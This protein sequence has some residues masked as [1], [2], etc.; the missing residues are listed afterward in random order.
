[1][2]AG[3]A[4]IAA[5]LL[6]PNDAR[7]DCSGVNAV[8]CSGDLHDGV[9]Y[10]ST[11][12]SATDQPTS[13]NV[14]DV[15][16]AITPSVVGVS[17]L[18]YESANSESSNLSVT[19]DS[20]ANVTVNSILGYGV[21]LTGV[22]AGFSDPTRG[23]IA[24][25]PSVSITS[26]ATI[27]VTSQWFD[28]SR[29]Q[30]LGQTGLRDS[31][32]ANVDLAHLAI[33]A[34][35]GDQ[36]PEAQNALHTLYCQFDGFV[37]VL[38]AP[39]PK[40]LTPQLYDYLYVQQTNLD[41]WNAPQ[42]PE[43]RVPVSNA[44][45]TSAAILGESYGGSGG[46]PGDGGG[47]SIINTGVLTTY[48]PGAFG[49]L[50]LSTSTLGG[51]N[52]DPGGDVRITNSNA[53][54]TWGTSSAGIFARSIGSQ[55]DFG[56]GGGAVAVDGAG[57]ITTHGVT[58]YGIYAL[59]IGGNS[60]N[61]SGYTTSGNGGVVTVDY[62]G[63][64][65]TS[66]Y[67]ATGITA[68]SFGGVGGTGDSA[69][70]PDGPLG[71]PANP[72]DTGG[73]G[74]H[75]A[76]TLERGGA[77]ETTADNA[78]ALYAA[79]RGGGGGRG[80][81]GNNAH[82]A[83]TGGLGGS[84]GLAE[85]V[86]WGSVSTQ[87]AAS[88]GIFAQSLAGDGGG[89]GDGDNWFVGNG[90]PGG[91]A[92]RGG[93]VFATNHGTITTLG[94]RSF[95]IFAESIGGLG[96]AGGDASG[97]FVAHPGGGGSAASER[98]TV[99][100]ICPNG[101]DVT[102]INTGVIRTSGV[103]AYDIFAQ[104]IG[105]GGGQGGDGSGWISV[106]GG[107]GGDAG[108]GGTVRVTNDVG[109]AIYSTGDRATAIFSQSIGGGG[110]NGGDATSVGAFA[111][112]AVGA[113]GGAGGDGGEVYVTNSGAITVGGERTDAIL[114]QSVGGGGGVGGSATAFSVGVGGAA[115]IAIGG[116]GGGGGDGEFVE[117]VTNVEGAITTHGDFSV[118]IFAQSVGGGGGQGGAAY[119][120]SAAGGAE[121]FNL[122][123]S[124]SVGGKGV[125]GGVGGDVHVD[126]SGSIVT[127][128]FN[129]EGVLAQSVGGGGGVGGA[130]MAQSVTATGGEGASFNVSVAVG[131]P[132]GKGGD[133]GD[134][135]VDNH[136]S[137]TTF[138]DGST[139][140][141]AQ[142]V[143]GGGGAGGDASTTSAAFSTGESSSLEL[144]I[145][146]GGAGGAAGNGGAVTV[147]NYNAITTLGS[148]ANGVT[149]QSVG[150]GGGIGGAGDQ[151][152][153]FEDVDIPTE[154]PDTGDGD[155]SQADRQAA[156][157][158]YRNLQNDAANAP[159]S[160]GSHG[161]ETK[162]KGG[163][164]QSVGLALSLGGIG[165][166]GGDGE[167]VTVRNSGDIVTGG[168][169]SMG[170]F[171]QSVGGGGGAGG[172]GSA[173]A[174][175]DVSLGAGLG[176][177]GGAAGDGGEVWVYNTGSIS[178]L[179]AMSYGVFA[180]SIGGGGGL[181]GVG[182]GEGEG[183]I[184]LTLG[185][186]GDAGNG[187][188][189]KLVHVEQ[190]GDVVTLGYAAIGVFAQSVGG[191]GGVGGSASEG[192]YGSIALGGDGGSA[193]NGGIVELVL[194][195]NI[196]TEGDFAHGVFAQSVGGGGGL[197]GGVSTATYSYGVDPFGQLNI[198]TG[199]VVSVGNFGMGGSGGA[200][201]DGQSVTVASNG[202][203]STFGLGAHGI[204]AQSIGGGGGA[205][206]TGVDPDTLI[207]LGVGIAG[208][209]GGSGAAGP[210]TITHT[211]DIHTFGADSAGIYAQS[212]G[213]A[214]SNGRGGDITITLNGGEVQGG[215]GAAGVGVFVSGGAHNEI[216]NNGGDIW[217]LSGVAI[218]ATDGDDIVINRGRIAGNVGLGGGANVF[219]NEATGLF[220][221]GA[222]VYIGVTLNNAGI[223]SPFGAN[224]VGETVIAGDY[225]QSASGQLLVDL[226]FSAPSDRLTVQ[227]DATLGGRVTPLIGHVS[228]VHV[229]D[230]V[231]VLS[232]N[233]I[234]DDGISI[235]RADTLVIDYAQRISGGAFQIGVAG[236]N[237]T[238]N[239]LNATERELAAYFQNIWAH[240]GSPALD[241]VMDWM[242][243][244]TSIAPYAALMDELHP[245][246]AVSAGPN[247]L[248][249]H[250][251]TLNDMLSCPGAFDSDDMHEQ[252]C[253][254]VR[255]SEVQAT[256]SASLAGPRNTN[257]G[258]RYQGGAQYVRD[259][260]VGGVSFGVEE[261]SFRV[262][263][264]AHGQTETYN[265]GAVLKRELG[266]W[267]IAG[268]I[269][270]AR[271]DVD[272]SR[273]TGFPTPVEASSS[274]DVSAWSG[275][276]RVAYVAQSGGWYVRPYADLDVYRLH[277]AA[278]SESG[279]GALDL[280]VVDSDQTLGAA[281]MS[282]E[283]GVRYRSGGAVLHPYAQIGETFLS[284]DH[285]DL[286]ARFE[287]APSGSPTFTVSTPIPDVLVRAQFGFEA[288]F[289]FGSIRLEYQ[290]QS[291]DDYR[292]NTASAK[293][294]VDF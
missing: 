144:T 189:G 276:L 99:Q 248:L 69:D 12:P 26:A 195:G 125:S 220:E 210:V 147:N 234:V 93:A 127:Y 9:S 131:G 143:G 137:I 262:D 149:A 216:T 176:G 185:M 16:T 241:P 150:G 4:A 38:L 183:D 198:D 139:G 18:R 237:F 51:F 171:A 213:G 277:T 230:Y 214:G 244:Q 140:V 225:A 282:V 228:G 293:L 222:A 105:G 52:G 182:A 247:A 47:V 178:T 74:G 219:N 59:S 162:K 270:Y 285:L 186:G 115:S 121:D 34:L 261:A 133:G 7:A 77:V 193:S 80:G 174:N 187:G 223:V 164:G 35:E 253:V 128:D 273:I 235:D 53:I 102:V 30:A 33:Q 87:G 258:H 243:G 175:G 46:V 8:D 36:S 25:G 250:A 60:T 163:G 136:G 166:A 120:F 204:F 19:V 226:N 192:T 211:G 82:A 110:G 179:Q 290:A 268:A 263:G 3:T 232:A 62:S 66:G 231:T 151:S 266:A 2:S 233:A 107:E 145:S 240:G 91:A 142:S 170:V 39:D 95:G 23:V 153:L 123:A 160:E 79:S 159:E 130:S 224:H 135:T 122:A 81:S 287:G 22:G 181:A 184:H 42:P 196:A 236:V 251:A 283:A 75:A 48:G 269:D 221:T 172:G 21:R 288:Q 167:T 200:G 57:S 29:A 41:Y 15:A 32:Q 239:G 90:G 209:D 113:H 169:M 267:Q 208:S 199:M 89:G 72:G 294:R 88:Y 40:L 119:S 112:V 28:L 31:Y 100:L 165:G 274:N 24:P 97:I 284:G 177:A 111:A 197:A 55:S 68:L 86:N 260:W 152:P 264:E 292:D 238:P 138:G 141:F 37:C 254:W 49:I 17:L 148:M 275:R 108:N 124:I 85:V 157:D 245:H 84:G 78:T 76:V 96:G 249:S 104:S 286:N 280:Q 203:I 190:T 229:G 64:V 281:S 158:R 65:T 10:S 13:I 1:M 101:G 205:G 279:A 168:F 191:G 67:G 156:R 61:D 289:G 173:S 129:S 126:N 106:S 218:A 180:Q 6:A 14:H 73:D 54:T 255:S 109:G 132:G 116:D 155:E 44:G 246:S 256:Q 146:L 50:G 45:L 201:G 202:S 215:S 271:G 194:N 252:S 259:G 291:G 27:T 207:P 265:L 20:T 161:R 114:A 43:E 70:G 11:D 118:G 154:P 58:A 63:A 212:M 278:F 56:G 83:G 117:V 257:H 94:E 242:A 217:S 134:V 188:E 227:G 272:R 92:G 5:M 103:G 98:C 206:A 71:D